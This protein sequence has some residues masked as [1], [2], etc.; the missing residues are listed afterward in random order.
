M[1]T[2]GKNGQPQVY[3]AFHTACRSDGTGEAPCYQKDEVHYSDILIP[4][5]AGNQLKLL[6]EAQLGVLEKCDG[7][8]Q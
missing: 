6:G 5:T 2:P 4:H 7:R 3:R 8:V 1:A